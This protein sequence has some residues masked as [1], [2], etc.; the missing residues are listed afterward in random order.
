MANLLFTFLL[1]DSMKQYFT[2]FITAVFFT[3]SVFLFV[4]AKKRTIENLTVQKITIVDKIGNQLGEIGHKKNEPYMWL[5]SR[6]N[7]KPAIMLSTD[8]NNGNIAVRN[9]N[10]AV[11]NSAGK[12]VVNIGSN[13]YSGGKININ[14]KNGSRSILIESYGQGNGRLLCYN[15]R[16][17]E[18]LFVGTNDINSGQ[19]KTYNSLGAET[20]FLGTDNNDA[21]LVSVNNNIGELRAIVGVDD[22]GK[23]NVEIIKK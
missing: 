9:G 1:G 19:I 15:H 2:G 3:S 6:K 10:I 17:N 7:K 8:N 22:I 18:T 11:R 23:G 12:D 13:K 14:K 20:V 5:K 4:G 21:G 16:Q